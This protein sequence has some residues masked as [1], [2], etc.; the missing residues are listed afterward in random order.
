MN[1]E[2]AF[3]AKYQNIQP[4]LSSWGYLFRLKAFVQAEMRSSLG[5]FV[6][7]KTYS[8][9]DVSMYTPIKIGDHFVTCRARKLVK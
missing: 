9:L 1:L 3:V 5:I 2:V 8:R 7:T 6:Y 4:N